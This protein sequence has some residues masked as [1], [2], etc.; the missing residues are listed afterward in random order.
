[1]GHR[2]HHTLWV[3]PILIIEK[4]EIRLGLGIRF[5]YNDNYYYNNASL[6]TQPITR[7]IMLDVKLVAIIVYWEGEETE[8]N[9]SESDEFFSLC[10]LC[11]QFTYF[12]CHSVARV[13]Y[14]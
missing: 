3:Y 8:S 5:F 7:L 2:L 1:M 4:L 14:L 9:E 13:L 12:Y 6:L 11:L 10:M